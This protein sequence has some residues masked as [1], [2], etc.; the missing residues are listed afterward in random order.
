M[1]KGTTDLSKAS[2]VRLSRDKRSYVFFCIFP[3]IFV[4]DSIVAF[5][6]IRISMS[7]FVGLRSIRVL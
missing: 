2:P 1:M 4:S 3:T 6:R 7:F 5:I